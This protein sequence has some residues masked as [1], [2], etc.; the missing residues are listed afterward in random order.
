[1]SL[2]VAR[3]S[4]AL[5]AEVRGIDLREQMDGAT[6]DRI[7]AAFAEHM[8]LVF[9]D[10][11]LTQADQRRFAEHFGPLGVRK[12]RAE[13]RPEGTDAE[14]ARFMRITNIRRNG[15]PVGSLPDGEVLLHHDMCYVEAPDRATML[16]AIQ[17]PSVGG[18]TVFANMCLAYDTLPGELR[19]KIEGRRV[20]QVYDYVYNVRIDPKLDLSRIDQCMQPTV[21]RHPATGRKALYI[22]PLMSVGIEGLTPEESEEVVGAISEHISRPEHLYRHRWKP[23]DLV[24]WD[25]LCTCHARTDFPPDEIREMRRCTV[26]GEPVTAAC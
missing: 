15:V 10:Q 26:A 19:R 6:K 11:D 22:N 16:Y 4:P 23:G 8:V 24:M 12:R 13:E 9:P 25:N 7:H 20:N 14:A 21:L 2:T 1:M 17:V 3:L 5:A 18:D